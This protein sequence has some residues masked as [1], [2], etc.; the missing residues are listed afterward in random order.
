MESQQNN[1]QKSQ[2]DP[3]LLMIIK[4]K[5]CQVAIGIQYLVCS[6]K[7]TDVQL[8]VSNQTKHVPAAGGGDFVWV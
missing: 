7:E 4:K 2:T 6:G 3:E 8:N 5:K 1:V